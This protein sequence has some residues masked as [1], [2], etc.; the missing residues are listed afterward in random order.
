MRFDWVQF[1]ERHHIEYVT[2]GPNISKNSV[3]VRCPFC[4]SA[5]P[6][7][8]MSIS[9]DGRGWVC[10]RKREHSGK[11]RTKLIKALLRCS[12]ERARELAG[13][14]AVPLPADEDLGDRVRAALGVGAREREVEPLGW[15]RQEFRRLRSKLV[16]ARPYINYLKSRGY[17]SEEVDWLVENYDLHYATTGSFAGRIIFPIKDHFGD[18]Q[19]FVGRTIRKDEEPRY[20]ASY[21]HPPGDWLL[22]LPN[23][24][25]AKRG[26]SLIIVEGPLD[27]VKVRVLGRRYNIYST[28]LFGLNVTQPQARLLRKVVQDFDYVG[29]MLDE[30]AELLTFRLQQAVGQGFPRIEIPEGFDDPGELTHKAAKELFANLAG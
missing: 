16:T 14:S 19:A 5:D 9:L 15:P 1:L 12:E 21:D 10:R 22:D 11:S 6:S 17:S 23:L 8:H 28:C 18:V 30:G 26:S 24:G 25:R 4:G 27:A 29:W 20:K 2:R 3:G 13:E 7:Q